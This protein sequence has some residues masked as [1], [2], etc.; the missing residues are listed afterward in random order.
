MYKNTVLISI[1]GKDQPGI[2]SSLSEILAETN[3]RILDIEQVVIH[4]LLSLSILIR[5]N[6][7][8]EGNNVLKELLF[9]AKEIG[10][11]LD[12]QVITEEEVIN[13]S[14]RYTYAVTCLGDEI[15]A[16]VILKLSK[17]LASYNANIERIK[18]LN[19][20][21]INCIELI[22]YA[23]EDIKIEELKTKLLTLGKEYNVDIA[24]Q[25]ENLYRKSKRLLVLDMDMT[26]VQMEIIDEL[27]KRA[28][29]EE[30]VV[31]IT[32]RAMNGEIDF[33]NALKERVSLLKGLSESE[34]N[35]VYERIIFTDG[36]EVLINVAKHLGFKTAVISGG[37]TYFTDKIK[38]R[39]K[40]DYAYA[41]VL[42]IKENKLTGEV[43][44][45][46]INGKRKAELMEEIAQ[47]ENI[48]LDQVV[49]VG[50]GAND[51]PM[52]KKAG[53][54]VAF[55]AKPKVKELANYSISSKPLNSIFYLLGI[56]EK[57]LSSTFGVIQ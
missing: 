12:F 5:L 49:A 21:I 37:F 25:K 56:N 35:N 27:A 45:D 1:T 55:N 36:A 3:T 38:E 26:L 31:K 57:D 44:G 52:L 32:E 53:L 42:E 18:K 13:R 17:T 7:E 28:G 4:D 50:D 46:I 39:L 15:S 10:V 43:L 51:L 34:L 40:L 24:I 30:Q 6:N 47:R 23:I 20:G 29:V 14:S 11:N 48:S 33:N 9:K 2:T 19:E 16:G 54:G 22:V 8:T 41:N